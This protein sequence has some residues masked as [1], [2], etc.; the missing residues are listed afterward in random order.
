MRIS[1][2]TTFV[3]AVALVATGLAADVPQMINYQG[4]L[5]NSSGEPLDT[6]VSMSFAIYDALT[7]G[8]PLWTETHP[9]VVV[10]DG[11][12]NVI[13]GSSG[14][15]LPDSVLAG[16]GRYLGIKVGTDSELS[17]RTRL[18]S[19]GYAH[20][21]SSID[22]ADA[23]DLTGVIEIAPGS[24]KEG[25]LGD[26]AL[27]VRGDNADSVVISPV[28]DI[29][30]YSTN[31]NGDETIR[32]TSG[33]NGGAMHVTATDVAKGTLRTIEINPGDS[34]V[35]SATEANGDEVVLI[36]ADP[37]GGA[38]HVTATDVAKATTGSVTI[39]PA[40]DVALLAQSSA[41]DSLVHISTDNSAGH[42]A[43][44]SGSGKGLRRVDI[45]QD[46]I[47]FF[48]NT[49]AD[50]TMIIHA[51][52]SITGKGQLAM[53]QENAALATWSNVLGYDNDAT[54]DSAVVSGGYNNRA[55]GRASAVGG[56]SG[57]KADGISSVIGGGT[58]NTATGVL[59]TIA[60]GVFDST[61]GYLSTVSGGGVNYARGEG[62]YIGGGAYNEADGDFA[63]LGGGNSNSA[64]GYA[65]TV[66]GGISNSAQGRFGLAAGRRA[67][68]YHTGCFVWADSTNANFTS[69]AANQFLIRASGGVGI[70]TNSPSA[71]LYVAGVAIIED[72]LGIGT[73]TP[74]VP[75]HVMGGSDVTVSAG[76][77]YLTVGTSSRD[78]TID[79][80]EI[81]AHYSGG[82]G[83]LSINSGS[84]DV[85]ICGSSGGNVGIGTDSPSEKLH[86]AGNICYTG[87]IGACS[88]ARYK[89]DVTE[90]DAALETVMQMRGVSY[91][92]KQDKYPEQEFDEQTHIGFIAQE[93]QE[94][95]PS[96]VMTDRDGYMSVDYSRLT[97]L[98]VEAVKEL[99]AENDRLS[100]ELSEI[101][102][103]LREL[104]DNR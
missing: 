73:E 1:T 85:V 6:T 9:A 27:I 50:T 28:D 14:T 36:T 43:L 45:G 35:L 5:V 44:V 88:D 59:S 10:N 81:M 65:S 37:S 46:G 25:R 55:T 40:S 75:L 90:I 41:G 68:A 31:D 52:G 67:R 56:G 12:F 80:N 79:D 98:L 91:K 70:N 87:S 63:V 17:P 11:L 58:S 30:I 32:M 34:I 49:R 94:L 69:T 19:A 83:K 8:S 38:M 26:A 21:V 77:G 20:R 2:V 54:G 99:K 42:I 93:L 60:G 51:D 23:G 82:A 39:D 61:T 101:K 103:L 89:K 33:S 104:I 86:V 96:V 74:S 71:D 15:P 18:V 53:G 102:A 13:L 47:Y 92:W 64:A 72:T 78:I 22:G 95:L 84:G 7:E 16:T 62:S 29:T 3:V 57:N 24:G 48:D 4:R 76:G 97:P 66:P 100:S